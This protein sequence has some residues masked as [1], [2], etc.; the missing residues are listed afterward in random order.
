MNSLGSDNLTA[1][2]LD[3]LKEEY[4]SLIALTAA[5]EDRIMKVFAGTTALAVTILSG[6][7]GFLFKTDRVSYGTVEAYIA[8][9]PLLL[10]FPAFLL[11]ID[12]RKE[13]GRAAAYFLVFIEEAD[14][15]P[16]WGKRLLAF[17]DIHY[18]ESLDTMPL[19][20]WLVTLACSALF[21]VQLGRTPSNGGIHY[22]VLFVVAA[23]LVYCTKD[24]KEA[25]DHF[26]NSAE[27][28]RQVK[29]RES[30][31]SRPDIIQAKPDTRD[32]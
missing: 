27:I 32:T 15:G 10:I 5:T 30:I 6:V 4:K 29:G 12:L 21:S 1:S 20:F 25:L 3:F 7:C 19:T 8:L 18:S 24:W 11:M 13:L 17:R 22:L 28:W 14:L 26:S 23:S 16:L 2:Q 31:K 9:T